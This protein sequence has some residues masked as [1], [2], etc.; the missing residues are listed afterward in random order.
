MGTDVATRRTLTLEQKELVRRTIAPKATDD[1]LQ[2]FFAMC[3]RTGLDPFSKQIYLIP[4]TE[5]VNVSG[6][7][8]SV[9]KHITVTSIDGLRLIAERTGRYQGQTQ[10]EWCGDDGQ[11]R[12]VWLRAGP[13]AAARVGVYRDGF[14]EPLVRVATWEQFAQRKKDGSPTATWA[15]MGPHMLAIR[16][17]GFA[18]RAAFPQELAGLYTADEMSSDEHPPPTV[19]EGEVV[20]DAPAAEPAK[21]RASRKKDSALPAAATVSA[22]KGEGDVAAAEPSPT[23]TVDPEG[24]GA[25]FDPGGGVQTVPA[26]EA[27]DPKLPDHVRV[28]VASL[29]AAVA[30]GLTAWTVDNTVELARRKWQQPDLELAALTEH[31]VTEILDGLRAKQDERNKGVA[32]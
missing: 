28:L 11:W 19:I 12:D 21:K 4:R 5:N 3:E 15:K 8:R 30:S 29:D 25:I 9:E 7:W 27:D 6:Q 22:D 26:S 1:E 10:V 31:Q 17:E 23:Y 24:T 32:A 20:R 14:T 13:P 16:A 2:L 18:L